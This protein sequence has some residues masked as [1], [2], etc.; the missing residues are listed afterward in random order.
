MSLLIS[1][2]SPGD[3]SENATPL[4]TGRGGGERI[5]MEGFPKMNQSQHCIQGDLGEFSTNSKTFKIKILQNWLS[6]SV[7]TLERYHV[8]EIPDG[9]PCCLK[10]LEVGL[11]A[12]MVPWPAT[13]LGLI[14]SRCNVE[15]QEDLV[16]SLGTWLAL[17]VSVSQSSVPPKWSWLQRRAFPRGHTSKYYESRNTFREIQKENL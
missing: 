11:W 4:E 8:P 3:V 9:Q 1:E 13:L 14:C 2:S 15:S 12:S 5:R 16:T 10:R 6:G 7:K 17:W